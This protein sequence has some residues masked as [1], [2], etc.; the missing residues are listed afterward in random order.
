MKYQFIGDVHGKTDRL[1]EGLKT[2]EADS[3]L[4][5]GDMGLGFQGVNLPKLN[6]SF[7][8]IRGNHDAPDMCRM[9]PNYA[10]EY[11]M[12]NEVFVVGGAYSIDW[13]YRT[14]GTS[15]WP[16]EEL[17]SNSL[18]SMLELYLKCKPRIVASHEAPDGVGKQLLRDGNFREYK[19]SSTESRTARMMQRMWHHHEPEH[20]FFGHYHRDWQTKF[21]NTHFQCLNELSTTTLEV[22]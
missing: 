9:H 12:W 3:I 16:N 11:G 2:T 18:E 10:G 17:D 15:W 7:G 8:F 22:K 6:S 1:L 13:L 5:L 14:P 20:W 19:F 21:G 4:Q